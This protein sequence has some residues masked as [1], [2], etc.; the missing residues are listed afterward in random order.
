[1][2]VTWEVGVWVAKSI[3]Q[4]PVPVF[5]WEGG[6]D[7]DEVV[8]G[9]RTDLCRCRGPGWAC[10]L[11]RGLARQRDLLLFRVG[12]LEWVERRQFIWGLW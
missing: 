8:Y 11:G 4:M 5:G 3:A 10:R 1:M 7:L 12:S 2:P 9:G 6:E